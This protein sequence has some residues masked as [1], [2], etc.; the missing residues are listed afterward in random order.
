MC[1]IVPITA[2]THTETPLL[3]KLSPSTSFPCSASWPV[4]TVIKTQP[5]KAMAPLPDTEEEVREREVINS[6]DAVH[7]SSTNSC[8]GVQEKLDFSS[9][10][11]TVFKCIL[12]EGLSLFIYY[13]FF[14]IWNSSF[15][16]DGQLKNTL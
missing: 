9:V 7:D 15:M 11:H 8:S 12:I 4:Y 13:Y 14:H 1:V 3:V 5:K 16:S 6:C 2:C 10:S